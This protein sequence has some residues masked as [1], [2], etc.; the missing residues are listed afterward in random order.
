MRA[1]LLAERR[2]VTIDELALL[3]RARERGDVGPEAYA[4]ERERLIDVL[5]ASLEGA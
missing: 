4:A 2:Q 5:A 3:D 1:K